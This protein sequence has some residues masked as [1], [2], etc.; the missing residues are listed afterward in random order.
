MAAN[1]AIIRAAGQ[2]YAPQKF[3]YSGYIKGLAS[4]T[5]VLNNLKKKN[6]EEQ[7]TLGSINIPEFDFVNREP[8]YTKI[9]NS[10]MSAKKKVEWFED[11]TEMVNLAKQNITDIQEIANNKGISAANSP[12]IASFAY[13][14]ASVFQDRII[15]IGESFGSAAFTAHGDFNPFVG[16]DPETGHLQIVGVDGTI[17]DVANMIK[18]SSIITPADGVEIKEVFNKWRNGPVKDRTRAEY[19]TPF[20]DHVTSLHESLEIVYLGENGKNKLKSFMLD[21]ETRFQDGTETNFYDYVLN[22][23][24]DPTLKNQFNAL[25]DEDPDFG[26]NDQAIIDV[27]KEIVRQYVGED[28]NDALDLFKSFTI[29]IANTYK[30]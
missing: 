13:N 14:T 16:S 20:Q 7:K 21:H 8:Q 27:K 28:W 6:D 5:N 23:M 10:D 25:I 17:G 22:N 29:E 11:E 12:E 2:R 1:E 24:E 15:P 26:D 18:A 19:K 3:D 30:S 9:R 4:I